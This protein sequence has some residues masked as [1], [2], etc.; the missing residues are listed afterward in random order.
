MEKELLKELTKLEKK[1]EKFITKKAEIQK[2]IDDVDKE[3]KEYKTYKRQ[4]ENLEKRVN[5][6]IN[7]KAQEV[8]KDE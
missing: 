7:N 6:R 4:Y 8:K 2:Q 1:K 5:N 3:I